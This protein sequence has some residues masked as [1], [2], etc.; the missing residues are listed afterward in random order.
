MARCCADEH[1]GIGDGQI[2]IEA[3]TK[4]LARLDEVR[5]GRATG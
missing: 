3:M 5:T 2:W 4:T 1:P